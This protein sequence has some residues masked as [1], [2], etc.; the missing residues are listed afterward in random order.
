MLYNASFTLRFKHS[1]K[2]ISDPE[3][4]I[5][6]GVGYKR[7]RQ[8][9]SSAAESV[10]QEYILTASRLYHGLSTK[11]MRSL[12]HQYVVKDDVTIPAGSCDKQHA[13]CVRL[14]SF[15][16]WKNTLSIRTARPTIL[17]RAT[18]FNKHSVEMLFAN[19]SK[20]WLVQVSV[21]KRL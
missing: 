6:P 5:K 15:L 10:L 11:D 3:R 18:S 14:S 4:R 7:P 1:T 8:V 20:V 21:P 19:L 12:A 17:G 13:S 2:Y 16:K 9:V